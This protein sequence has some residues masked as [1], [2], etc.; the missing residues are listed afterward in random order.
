MPCTFSRKG[1]FNR[2]EWV[3]MIVLAKQGLTDAL[4]EARLEKIP[5]Y[6]KIQ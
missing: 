2:G 6:I 1:I 5:L 4:E 3:W